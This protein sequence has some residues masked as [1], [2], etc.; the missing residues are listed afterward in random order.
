MGPYRI[1]LKQKEYFVQQIHLY[2]IGHSDGLWSEFDTKTGPSS[3][4][5]V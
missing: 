3:V 2:S 5:I 1:D 4:L